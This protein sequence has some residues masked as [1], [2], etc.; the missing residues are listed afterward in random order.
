MQEYPRITHENTVPKTIAESILIEEVEIQDICQICRNEFEDDDTIIC[1]SCNSLTH[2]RCMSQPN[3][4]FCFAC[5]R[6]REQ[7]SQ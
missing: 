3:N 2:K 4:D 6:S 5:A 1:E 7:V